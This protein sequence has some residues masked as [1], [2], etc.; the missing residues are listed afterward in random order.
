MNM[1]LLIHV[2]AVIIITT[3]SYAENFNLMQGS[4]VTVPTYV[5]CDPG[6]EQCYTY[7][8]PSGDGWA[9]IFYKLV[10]MPIAQATQSGQSF[11]KGFGLYR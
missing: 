10:Y 11:G 7:Y 1:H 5:P 3:P 6:T 2:L 4:H 8:Q 9:T